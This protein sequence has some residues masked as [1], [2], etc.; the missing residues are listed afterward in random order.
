MALVTALK[1]CGVPSTCF[2]A[3]LAATAGP[4]G[5]PPGLPHPHQ[6]P[7]LQQQ[8]G[9]GL[10]GATDRSV[11]PPA[12]GAGAV[13]PD[14][15]MPAHHLAALRALAG[16]PPAVRARLP[17]P[18]PLLQEQQ[19]WQSC[20]PP[21]SSLPGAGAAPPP[22]RHDRPPPPGAATAGLLPHQRLLPPGARGGPLTISEY[23]SLARQLQQ[24]AAAGLGTSSSGAS[25]AAPPPPPPALPV[26]VAPYPAHFAAALQLQY[27]NSACGGAGHP[28]AAQ[29]PPPAAPG[30]AA[31]QLSSSTDPA[32]LQALLQA[33][34]MVKLESEG[35]GGRPGP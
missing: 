5:P 34:L 4:P 35:A 23:A 3:R 17:S 27:S 6:H 20:V 26:L 31:A 24:A 32:H 28:L 15:A 9:S 11:S 25:M 7:H 22:P 1:T 8:A 13:A 29:P 2:S 16:L 19:P 12:D 10:R 30:P 18:P 33:L 21:A 14:C